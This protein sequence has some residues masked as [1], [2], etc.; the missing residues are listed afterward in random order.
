MGFDTKAE[1]EAYIRKLPVRSAFFAPGS[2][3]QNWLSNLKPQKST[4]GD[5]YVE[6]FVSPQTQLPLIDTAGD[7]GKFVGAILA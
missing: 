1:I 7:N 5:Y 2:F 4:D 3:M 6:R